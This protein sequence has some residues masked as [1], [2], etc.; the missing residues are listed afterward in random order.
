MCVPDRSR[1]GLPAHQEVLRRITRTYDAEGNE[2]ITVDYIRKQSDMEE[3]LKKREQTL[4]ESE[5]RCV[6]TRPS[7]L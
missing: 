5:R 3:Y 1:G 7:A 2:T 6:R 4:L